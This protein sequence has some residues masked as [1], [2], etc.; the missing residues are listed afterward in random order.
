MER[1]IRGE[2]EKERNEH[3]REIVIKRV[4]EKSA[5]ERL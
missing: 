5:K 4:K 3:E 2:R 1:E